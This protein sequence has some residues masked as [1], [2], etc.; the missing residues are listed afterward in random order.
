MK[1]TRKRKTEPP[2]PDKHVPKSIGWSHA[3]IHQFL[4]GA[5]IS[6]RDTLAEHQAQA[7]RDRSDRLAGIILY[8]RHQVSFLNDLIARN[9]SSAAHESPSRSRRRRNS[10]K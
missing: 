4:H 1:T 2:E 5:L 6:S 8:F 9:N 7:M 3:V 10:D